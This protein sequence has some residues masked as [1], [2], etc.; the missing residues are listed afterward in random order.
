MKAFIDW[1][2]IHLPDKIL[3]VDPIDSGNDQIPARTNG[4][5]QED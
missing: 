2:R 4:N 3:W 1:Q 5:H